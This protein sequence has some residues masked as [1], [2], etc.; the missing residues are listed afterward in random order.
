[1]NVDMKTHQRKLPS[2]HLSVLRTEVLK[3]VPVLILRALKQQ[4]DA[5]TPENSL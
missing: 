3:T 4:G 1:M 5:L 2:L